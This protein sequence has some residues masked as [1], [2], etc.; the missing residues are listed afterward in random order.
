MLPSTGI[1]PSRAFDGSGRGDESF[2]TFEASDPCGL[3][4]IGRLSSADTSVDY[5]GHNF[6]DSKSSCEES[7]DGRDFELAVERQPYIGGYGHRSNLDGDRYNGVAAGSFLSTSKTTAKAEDE[8]EEEESSEELLE[9]LLDEQRELKRELPDAGTHKASIQAALKQKEKEINLARILVQLE[10]QLEKAEDDEDEEKAEQLEKKI[11]ALG[12]QLEF[13]RL[14]G[15]TEGELRETKIDLLAAERRGDRKLATFLV[16]LRESLQRQHEMLKKLQQAATKRRSELLEVYEIGFE[17]YGR[18]AH[19]KREKH[20]NRNK[21]PTTAS[22]KAHAERTANLLQLHERYAALNRKRL[23]AM[24]KSQPDQ[25][26]ALEEQSEEIEEQIELQ[27]PR[28]ELGLELRRARKEGDKEQVRELE[29]ELKELDGDPE[30]ENPPPGVEPVKLTPADMLMAQKLDFRRDVYP[31][32]TKHCIGCHGSQVQEGDLDLEQLA[33]QLPLVRNARVWRNVSEHVR[34]HVMPPPDEPQP[35]ALQRRKIAAFFQHEIEDFDYSKIKNPGYEVARRLTHHE[36]R[37]T[38]RDL[39]GLDVKV[40]DKF[41]ADL[42]GTSGFDNS[43]N[44]LFIQS[45]LLERYMAAADQVVRQALPDNVSTAAHAKAYKRTFFVSPD[46]A[47]SDSKAAR[48]IVT[49]FLSR[50]YRRP[51]TSREVELALSQYESSRKSGADHEAA[52]KTV[53]AAALVSPKFLMKHEQLGSKTSA[54]VINDW[55]LASRLSYFLWASMPDDQ[56]FQLATEKKL[57]DD[58]VLIAQVNRMLADPKA[59]A[60]GTVF[61]SQWLGFQHL[62][63]RVRA[64]PIDNPWCTE[65]LMTAMKAESAMFFVSLIRDNQPIQTLVNANFTY[66][67]EEL[68]RHYRLPGVKGD[69]MRRVELR[70]AN[71]GGIFTQ[72]SLLAVTSFPGRTSPVVRGKWIL[73]DVLGTPPPPPPPNVSEFSEAVERKRSLSR[74]QK[75]E[76]HRQNPNCYSCHSQID[77]LGF[78]LENYDWFGRYQA[79]RRRRPIDA[80]GRLPDGTAISGPAG[81]KKVIVEKRMPQLSRQLVRKMLSYSLG[82]QLEYYDEPAVRLIVAKAQATGNRFQTVVHEIVRSFPFQNKKTQPR[83]EVGS[84]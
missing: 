7:N 66:L 67:N 60:L 15:E 54:F 47:G 26:E 36:Y 39:F 83:M 16:S 52:I 6:L 64:D 37:H 46:E 44:T 76:L 34:Q 43:S 57:H 58:E 23:A 33:G 45:L 56:L 8:D 77:P 28:F 24:E 49:R 41:P 32:V 10:R 73:Q 69:R 53:I 38:V 30:S 62:G 82:R 1:R 68:A 11:E 81:L 79:S 48:S 3:V 84:E 5:N 51:T 65:S 29:M 12:E 20:R 13:L 71:R 72:G 61:A 27:W 75:L 74:R 25:V 18:I 70:T 21:K 22:D 42:S 35:N 19:L 59:A 80:S 63:T 4:Y 55:E 40:T 14:R 17:I 9:E 50:A 31:L 2:P 78:S